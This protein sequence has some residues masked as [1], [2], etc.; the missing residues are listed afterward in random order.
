MSSFGE[1][2][3]AATSASDLRPKEDVAESIVQMLKNALELKTRPETTVTTRINDD[4]IEVVVSDPTASE[5][6]RV[7]GE[8]SEKG[9]KHTFRLQVGE[10]AV[11]V[12]QTSWVDFE[13]GRSLL[14]QVYPKKGGLFETA[15]SHSE[16]RTL[17]ADALGTPAADPHQIERVE[18]PHLSSLDSAAHTP[19]PE[20][21]GHGIGGPRTDSSLYVP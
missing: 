4:Q 7:V 17:V 11:G 8:F 21:S 6:I 19:E 5:Q 10:R 20:T 16:L 15:L 9:K 1:H 3:R 14:S 2:L 13:L 18:R 12:V